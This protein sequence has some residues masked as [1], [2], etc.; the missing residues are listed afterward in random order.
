MDKIITRFVV[1]LVDTHYH[2]SSALA[3]FRH[4][5]DAEDFVTMHTHGMQ[6]ARI[7]FTIEAL[8]PGVH[9]ITIRADANPEDI[10]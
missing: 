5:C 4:R 3:L 2:T 1:L 9:T 6:S 10:T 7:R 8:E